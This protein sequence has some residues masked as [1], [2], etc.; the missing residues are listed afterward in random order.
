MCP[1]HPVPQL[2]LC[3]LQFST[4]AQ[5][6][7]T[8][9]DPMNCSAPGLPV[10]HQLR[11]F[12]QTHVQRVSDA[13]QPSHPLSSP[14]PPAP[15]SLPESE[16]FPMSQL[17]AIL[18]WHSLLAGLWLLAQSHHINSFFS[19]WY[20][21]MLQNLLVHFL[22]QTFSQSFPKLY[23]ETPPFFKGMFIET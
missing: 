23:L 6:C 14:P 21:R 8:L 11:G 10:H 5:S 9:C 1:L 19:V 13:I 4:V 17:F 16:S 20:D 15:K 2:H 22:K 7:P 3:S 18:S 12:T